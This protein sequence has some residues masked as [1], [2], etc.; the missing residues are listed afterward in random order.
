MFNKNGTSR[1]HVNTNTQRGKKYLLFCTMYMS[2]A[3]KN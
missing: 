2:T 3:P 1:I